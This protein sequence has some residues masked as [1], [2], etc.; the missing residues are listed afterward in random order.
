MSRSKLFISY[1]QRDSDWMDRLKLHLAQLERRGIVHIWSD[2]QVRIGDRWELEIESAL[3]ESRAA[4]LLITPAFLASEYIWGKELPHILEHASA[5]MRVFPLIAR[6][7]AWRI[8]SELAQLQARP[9]NGRALS[10]GS[11]PAI[12]SDLADL[13]Y[14]LASILG[15]MPSSMAREELERSSRA[16]GALRASAAFGAR[17]DMLVKDPAPW[18]RIAS[19]WTGTYVPT[20]RAMRLIISRLEDSGDFKGSIR[21]T[22]DDAVTD[23]A[24]HVLDLSEARR[25]AAFATLMRAGQPVDGA[26]VF[27]EKPVIE[28]RKQPLDLDGEYFA[29]ILGRRLSGVWRG[30]GAGAEPFE[31]TC[32]E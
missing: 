28:S 10:L 26:I 11:E 24:G 5:G 16:Q 4:V 3:A 15:E 14:E 25:D 20:N 17:P 29:V 6:P 30:R 2:T 9:R 7:C 32:D 27:R 22:D 1:S 18:L 31:F 8:A 12:D 21:Y 19:E 23:V 13:A